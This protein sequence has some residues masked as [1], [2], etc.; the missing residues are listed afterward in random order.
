MIKKIREWKSEGHAIIIHTARHMRTCNGN[1]E[2]VKRR[3][4]RITLEWLAKWNVPYDEIYYGKPH[5]DVY[6]DDL[7]IRYSSPEE[8]GKKILA[9]KLN[10]V[11][12][13][14]GNGSRFQAAG[15]KIPKFMIKAGNKSLFEWAMDSLPLD[16]A[17][18]IFFVCL[19]EH[20]Q[21]DVANFIGQII[22]KKFPSLSYEIEYLDGTTG[23]Q[24]E[25]VLAC[26]SSINNDTSLAIYNIDTHFV[27][28]RLKSKL[29][30]AKD[31]NIDGIL[32]VFKH[33]DPKWSFIELDSAG[34]V[35]RL[36]EKDPISNIASTGFY[37]FTRGRDF[38]RAADYLIK[39]D[40]RVK[41]EFYV[42]EIY[43]ILIA[44]GKKFVVDFVD[45]FLPFGTPED[46]ERYSRDQMAL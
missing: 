28:Y 8:V 31:Q 29:L 7:A 33:T 36:T 21:Y 35:K 38:V 42:S 41:N 45:E 25:T 16:I 46:L 18:K 43:N 6:I 10:F 3:V 24:A 9:T 13:M 1:V 12:P 40:I 14:A 22:E 37:S 15:Y 34:F 2:E 17:K 27:S 39:N 11:M 19:K 30:I 23:G 20:K 32:G 26:R 44:D 4:G 5:G